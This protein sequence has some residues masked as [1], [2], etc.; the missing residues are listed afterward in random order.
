MIRRLR[1]ASTCR[2]EVNLNGVAVEAVVDTAAEITLISDRL[3]RSLRKRPP[4][5]E[6]VRMLGAGREME[7]RGYI[8]GPVKMRI[9][10]N[11]F[12]E[13]VYV[14]PIEDD[15]LLGIDFIV[16]EGAIIN[17]RSGVM[18]FGSWSVPLK[19]RG[20]NTQTKVSRVRVGKRVVVTLGRCGM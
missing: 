14:A 6:H 12:E 7:M 10:G 4:I 19:L 8:V 2:V 18:D 1:S 3:Y 17:T 9:G 16:R 15:M 13:N 20:S 11:W 5:L